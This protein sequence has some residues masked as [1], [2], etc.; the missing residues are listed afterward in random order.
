[1]VEPQ[2]VP[3]LVQQHCEQV[4]LVSARFKRPDFIQ[5]EVDLARIISAG[6]E[7]ICQETARSVKGKSSP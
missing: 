3:N 2:N 6:E 4:Y 5:V 7:R 1:M